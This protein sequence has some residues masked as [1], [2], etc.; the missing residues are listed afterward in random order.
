MSAQMQSLVDHFQNDQDGFAGI[1]T[2]ALA[3]AMVDGIERAEFDEIANSVYQVLGQQVSYDE[4]VGILNNGYETVQQV[5]VEGAISAAAQ[6]VDD[7][8]L[9]EATL[10]IASAAAWSAR[11]VNYKE[12]VQLQSL[13]RQLGINEHRYFELL[14]YGKQLVGR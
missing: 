12:G 5:G 6:V 13:A 2:A 7:W 3:V 4:I 11:G 10:A 14:A 8:A 9:R 1:I